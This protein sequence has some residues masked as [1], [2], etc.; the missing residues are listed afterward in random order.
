MCTVITHP[1]ASS[2][3]FSRVRIQAGIVVTGRGVAIALA[4]AAIVRLYLISSS[5][6]FLIE[7]RRASFALLERVTDQST[8]TYIIYK[9]IYQ[10]YP[11][12]TSR[13]SDKV[14][15]VTNNTIFPYVQTEQISLFIISDFQQLNYFNRTLSPNKH[16]II[17]RKRRRFFWAFTGKV[18]D[19]NSHY[20]L[21]RTWEPSN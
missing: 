6:G 9:Y 10:Q 18:F 12:A 15:T 2:E 20:K 21:L 7:E 5:E 11:D 16:L 14:P 8:S 17:E 1:S 4:W 19:L 13:F 3:V